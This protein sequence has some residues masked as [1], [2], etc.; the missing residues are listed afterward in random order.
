MN[1]FETNDQIDAFRA[2]WKQLIADGFHIPEKVAQ[3]TWDG[4]DIVTVGYHKVSRL[5]G[6]HHVLRMIVLNLPPEQAGLS[7]TH[8]MRTYKFANRW[9]PA[10][11][12]YL[13]SPYEG[14][15]T[16]E[17][18]SRVRQLVYSFIHER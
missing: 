3:T 6:A 10:S 12:D 2:R 16:D 14:L 11:Y 8:R 9:Q 13:R 15:F 17:Q 1:I 5:D 4:V 18:W 7:R